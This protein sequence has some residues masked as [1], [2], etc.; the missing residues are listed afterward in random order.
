MVAYDEKYPGYHW[1]NVKGYTLLN[2][3]KAIGL[4][5]YIVRHLW[6]KDANCFNT[7]VQAIR[8]T[9]RRK[10]GTFILKED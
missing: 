6:E 5:P 1:Q 10:R 8:L 3:L 4:S 7:S 9:F 2:T